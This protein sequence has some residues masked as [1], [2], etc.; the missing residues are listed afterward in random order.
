MNHCQCI[1]FVYPAWAHTDN[2]LHHSRE[3]PRIHAC[4]LIMK[5]VE[6]V[7]KHMVK[8]LSIQLAA[9]APNNGVLYI[10]IGNCML[11]VACTCTRT[12]TLSMHD[13]VLT[14]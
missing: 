10:I 14:Q 6:C 8:H 2:V 13:S 11:Y 7:M 4:A 9:S 5:F 1:V 3:T 12:C